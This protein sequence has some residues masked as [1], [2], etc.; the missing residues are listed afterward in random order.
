M[1]VKNNVYRGKDGDRP[2][3]RSDASTLGLGDK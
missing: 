3:P 2:E 1:A